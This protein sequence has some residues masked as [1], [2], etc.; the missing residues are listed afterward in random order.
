VAEL[1]ELQGTFFGDCPHAHKIVVP[2]KRGPHYAKLICKHCHKF[3]GWMPHP[4]NVR[5][6]KENEEILTALAKL[7]NL[8][9]W[10]RQF[11]RTISETTRLS[12][13]QQKKLL[14][15]R[16]IWLKPQQERRP[17]NDGFHG[18]TMSPDRNPSDN[19]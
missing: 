9:S 1:R 6:Q 3:F 2:E 15:I 8:P 7:P 4:E 19:V 18:E 13:K 17:A 5:Q 16:D 12:P 11:V 10:E 14:E